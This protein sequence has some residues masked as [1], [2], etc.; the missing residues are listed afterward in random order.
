M[1]SSSPPKAHICWLDCFGRAR[2][3]GKATELHGRSFFLSIPWTSLHTPPEWT[4]AVKV[5]RFLNYLAQ[6]HL[7]SVQLYADDPDSTG[8]HLITTQLTP[9]MSA[10]AAALGLGMLRLNSQL[11]RQGVLGL[12]QSRGTCQWEVVLASTPISYDGYHPPDLPPPLRSLYHSF[13]HR[14]PSTFSVYSLVYG[15]RLVIP[16]LPATLLGRRCF[17][18]RSVFSERN[19]VGL[20][21]GCRRGCRLASGDPRV[22]P[23]TPHLQ[24]IDAGKRTALFS[25]SLIDPRLTNQLASPSFRGAH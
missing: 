25:D 4:T 17:L 10:S 9:P 13:T 18:E 5:S 2:R 15:H 21:L 24:S 20:L 8:T 1:G 6:P 12:Y 14:F 23:S 19:A 3:R 7:P 11:G 16:N 22:H